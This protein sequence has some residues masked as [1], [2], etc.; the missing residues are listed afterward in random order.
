[1][2]VDYEGSG[3]NE[4]VVYV[5][6]QKVT[7]AKMCINNYSIDYN[8]SKSKMNDN[9][10]C[11]NPKLTIKVDGNNNEIE[12]NDSLVYNYDLIEETL[13]NITNISCNNLA[14]PSIENNTLTINNVFGDTTCFLNNSIVYAI[15]NANETVN[16]IIMIKDE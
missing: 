14:I 10:Y 16:N 4:G 7:R 15:S 2:I 5:E 3:P 12:L 1:M 8:D 9:N 13:N 6:N 11:K